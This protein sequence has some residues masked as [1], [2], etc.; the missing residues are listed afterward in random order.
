MA[1]N[2]S[3]CFFIHAS[4]AGS[5]STALLNRSNCVFIANPQY[6]QPVGPLK[7]WPHLAD[8]KYMLRS[9]S[10]RRVLAVGFAIA[11]SAPSCF[12][13]GEEGHR[14]IVRIA[15]SLMT[16]TATAQVQ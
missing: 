11:C 4:M 9:Y 7:A 2:S 13:W 6:R 8:K 15:E 5:C 14:L 1:P 10:M 16:P 12:G 3:G